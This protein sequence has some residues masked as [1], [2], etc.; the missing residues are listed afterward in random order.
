M[1]VGKSSKAP[2]N[3]VGCQNESE[4]KYIREALLQQLQPCLQL[5]RRVCVRWRYNPPPPQGKCVCVRWQY[6]PPPQPIRI[7][8]APARDGSK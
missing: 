2:K 7:N 4:E 3:T 1:R 8:T 6:N 5:P